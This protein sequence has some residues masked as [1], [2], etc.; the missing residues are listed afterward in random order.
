M[1]KLCN[2]NE[3]RIKKIDKFSCYQQ[4]SADIFIMGFFSSKDFDAL[5]CRIEKSFEFLRK[6]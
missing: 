3:I 2:I 4:N 6:L 1:G 5:H